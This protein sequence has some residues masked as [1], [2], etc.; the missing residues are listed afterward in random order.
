MRGIASRA[1]KSLVRRLA[2][3]A[4]VA[5]HRGVGANWVFRKTSFESREHSISV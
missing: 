3:A 4:A 1:A 5:R 2:E